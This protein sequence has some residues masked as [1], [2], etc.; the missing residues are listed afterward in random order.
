MLAELEDHVQ[1][2]LK[3][4][5]TIKKMKAV[6]SRA[7]NQMK[8]QVRKHNETY[9]TEIADFRAN[10]EKYAE[11]D[12]E[13]DSDESSSDNS[14]DEDSDGDESSS[15]EELAA[16]P[17]AKAAPVKKAAAGS[18]DESDDSLFGSDG[19]ESDDESES[20][21]DGR[22]ELKG[23]AKWLKK[24]TDVTEKGARFK[25]REQKKDDA[26]K[27][28]KFN[29]DYE[30]SSGS[31]K[32]AVY[33]AEEQISV[34]ELDRKVAELVASRGRKNTDVRDVLRQLE[35]LTKSARTHG[36][37]KEI[38]VLM[39][40][41]SAMFDSHRSIDDY[42]EHNQWRT[43][44]RSLTRI[45]GLLEADRKL[46]LGTVASD[47]VSDV[48]VGA[49]MRAKKDEEEEEVVVKVDENL[50]KVVGSVESFILRLEDEYTKSLQQINPHTKKGT[51]SVDVNPAPDLVLPEYVIRLS[52]EAS[53]V[54]LA[55]S[56]L[57]YYKRVHD[58]RAS[59]S[60]ALLIVEHL[61]YKHDSHAV[62]VHRAHAFNK[63][64]GRY[65]DLHP[66]CSGKVFSSS[67]SGKLDIT[68][69][70]EATTHPG[71]YLGNPTVVPPP[72]N[73][74]KKLEDLCSFIFKFGDERIKTRALLCSVYHHSLHDRYYQA[75][76]LFLISHIQ[77]FIEK[78]EVKTQILYNRTVVTL[79]LC[80]FRMGLF[81]KAHD[82]LT[83]I[84]S[85]RVKEL[86]AQGQMKWADKD[87]E[88]EKLERRRQIPYH[89]HIN[90]DLLECCHLTCAM[91]LELPHLARPP[92]AGAYQTIVS[93]QFRK[94]LHGYGKQVFTGP[95]ENTREHVL[96][97]TKALLA[98]DWQR[99]CD[100]ILGLEVW[101]LIPNEGGERVKAM[102][103][104][105]IKEE[106]VRTYLL[107]NG[108]H[109]DSLSLSHLCQMFG[110]EA[111]TTRRII[112]RMI[113]NKEIS[114]AWDSPADVLVMYKLDLTPLQ[115]LSQNVADKISL[116]LESNERLLDPLM[117]VYGY[118]DD[119]K[120][121][122]KQWVDKTG[123]DGQSAVRNKYRNVGWKGASQR[124][125]PTGRGGRGGRGGGRG[126]GGRGDGV[127]SAWSGA[128]SAAPATGAA[129]SVGPAAVKY[130]KYQSPNDPQTPP[131]KRWAT[132][133]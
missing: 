66:A 95:P 79:G 76:D 75:R 20:E 4:K 48:L 8:L 100:Y 32:V 27:V 132:T 29:K 30:L 9:K 112:C 85:G 60:V 120:D 115:T 40:L 106:A 35:V 18:D 37:K 82:C 39:H 78:A 50:L 53:I 34:E 99:A 81:Q 104:V 16:K 26:K 110:M 84:C 88:Q 128:N 111:A 71:A 43:C 31:K 107:L 65:G 114:A 103:Q 68:K 24:T 87:P 105:R 131:P 119:W 67:S 125:V 93:R 77:D 59:A 123:A 10:P 121:N 117:G 129:R 113:F 94:Y 42:M 62:A 11:A 23:R 6:V 46:V 58:D 91:I 69:G 17:K 122:R 72:F 22:K 74:T 13:S 45:M 33:Q 83:G 86:L 118:K 47:E 25:K 126:A 70:L 3:D 21:D 54:E 108:E 90:P 97:A 7:L 116:L 36:A 1:L 130:T 61:Y 14:S 19:E 80:A 28:P 2:A 92:V 73:P 64:W 109:Y 56:V 133:A 63:T 44:H 124:P 5:E 89:M 15:E 52:D 41:I 55:D 12:E 38:P 101:K 49:H 127:K 102:L 51:F 57:G 96:A 98:G